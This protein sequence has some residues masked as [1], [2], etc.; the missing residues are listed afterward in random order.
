[1]HISH[2]EEQYTQ[3]GAAMADP[4]AVV[5]AAADVT[6]LSEL[7]VPENPPHHVMTN[8]RRGAPAAEWPV[9]PV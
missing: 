7:V 4:I 8:G 2:A 6:R 5:T 3:A 1:M 9:W